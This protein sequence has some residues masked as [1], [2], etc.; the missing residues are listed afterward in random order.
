MSAAPVPPEVRFWSRVAKGTN[1]EC[2]LWQGPRSPLM[3]YGR[4]NDGTRIIM[5]HRYSYELTIGPIPEGLSVCHSC[6]T[7]SC[8]NP[9]HLWLGT[10]LDNMRD[11]STKGRSL[12]GTRSP[13]A[14]P[15]EVVVAIRAAVAA[16]ATLRETAE[17]FGVHHNTVY[18]YVKRL[19][20]RDVVPAPT[21]APARAAITEHNRN[22]AEREVARFDRVRDEAVRL[23]RSGLSTVG[24]ATALGTHPGNVSRM[25][26]DRGVKARPQRLWTDEQE[27]EIADDLRRLG[28]VRPVMEKWPMSRAV[29]SR[30]GRDHGVHLVVGR[31]KQTP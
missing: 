16:G 5:T 17:R 8:V 9:A 19:R 3:G 11:M 23:Y 27:A 28:S 13:R 10:H 24:V 20:H 6:D 2:W 31:R 4:F 26:R 14:Y 21:S 1:D 12:V 29:V 18:R 7:G 30:I 15:T 25:L 22:A